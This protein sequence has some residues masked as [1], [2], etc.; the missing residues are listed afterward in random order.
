MELIKRPLSNWLL[1]YLLITLTYVYFVQFEWIISGDGYAETITNY[2]RIAHSKIGFWGKIFS[3]DYGYATPLLR[4]IP[5]LS[6]LFNIEYKNELIIY[7]I[8][9]VSLSISLPALIFH[10]RYSC[11]INLRIL[12][13]IFAS[14]SFLFLNFESRIYHNISI[15]FSLPIFI[16]LFAVIKTNKIT[17]TEKFI[18]P[19]LVMGKPF[20][21]TLLVPLF[22]L[23]FFKKINR[24]YFLFIALIIAFQLANIFLNSSNQSI[25][26]WHDD[27]LNIFILFFY[28]IL[29]PFSF[30]LSS[31]LLKVYPQH[32][33]L[34]LCFSV[35]IGFIFCIIFIIRVKSFIKYYNIFI[36]QLFVNVLW[37]I[38]LVL[39]T[40]NFSFT[41]NN[42]SVD[43]NRYDIITVFNLLCLIIY[44]DIFISAFNKILFYIICFSLLTIYSSA[45]IFQFFSKIQNNLYYIGSS[46]WAL[47]N[48]FD[49]GS[50]TL[51]S[52]LGQGNGC[53][54]YTNI[55]NRDD[56]PYVININK[57]VKTEIIS[58]I[59]F[60]K[61]VIFEDDN[62]NINKPI[63]YFENSGAVTPISVNLFNNR[64][65]LI[66]DVDCIAPNRC[67]LEFEFLNN[68]IFHN[69]DNSLLLVWY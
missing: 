68:R 49:M 3:T 67:V 33:F 56:P 20:G 46:T 6:S 32:Y 10:D 34:T 35:L 66:Y 51:L 41:E 69:N 5:Y 59:R 4:I 2:Y 54:V 25:K 17:L 27:L 24:L 11:L 28:N 52:P 60:N 36:I 39:G 57:R 63:L 23:I 7:N 18:I 50:C 15:I 14:F 43:F 58:N 62:R 19:L 22:L 40:G 26:Y 29:K 53:I 9:A 13:F 21:I 45:S 48:Q 65:A 38:M 31:L 42:I 55:K 30:G 44:R 37:A 47:S 12:K 61:V 16:I 8:F 64:R 1:L